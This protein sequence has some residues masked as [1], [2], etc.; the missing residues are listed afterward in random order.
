MV[1]L[2]S[3]AQTFLFIPENSQGVWIMKIVMRYGGAL[4]IV[5]KIFEP[6]IF[7]RVHAT[8]RM[9]WLSEVYFRTQFLATLPY[10]FVN[11]FLWIIS[12]SL[13]ILG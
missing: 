6:E 2:N 5:K 12:S 9:H 3:K 11:D 13:Q 8:W 4:N 10:W 1:S 7:F